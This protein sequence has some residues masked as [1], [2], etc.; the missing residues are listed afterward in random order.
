LWPGGSVV[1]EFDDNVPPE[2]RANM[3]N[4]MAE[5]EAVAHVSFHEEGSCGLIHCVHIQNSN[6]NSSAVGR[7]FFRQY[8]NIF[9]WNLRFIICHELGH[10]LGFFHEQSR[11]DRN[12]YVRINYEH[13]DPS[14]R[15]NFDI[16]DGSGRYGPYDFD[17]VMHY[18]QFDF[19]IDGQP[20]ITVL[21]PNEEW[22]TRIGQ[23]SHLSRMDQMIMSFLYSYSNWRFVDG[24]YSGSE[25]GTFLQPYRSFNTGVNNTPNGGTLWVQPGVY[26]VRGTYTR[27]MTWRA[28]L[29]GVTLN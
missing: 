27:P 9:N 10:L 6:E 23:H 29:G 3:R 21:P 14:E 28:P 11:T 1:Y 25:Q 12:T 4:A 16:E 17:S 2:N 22:Q 19:S 26:S 5:W 20:T 24:S 13:I 8:V 18:G 15:Y 7:Q